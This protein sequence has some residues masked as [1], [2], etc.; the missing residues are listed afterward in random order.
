MAPQESRILGCVGP[1]VEV[2]CRIDF[3][4]S[5][6]LI[7]WHHCTVSLRFLCRGGIWNLRQ[8][9]DAAPQVTEELKGCISG[10]LRDEDLQHAKETFKSVGW[11]CMLRRPDSIAKR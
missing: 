6:A 5:S 8:S 3:L 9:A 4:E 1:A 10:V 2:P 7:C 11:W